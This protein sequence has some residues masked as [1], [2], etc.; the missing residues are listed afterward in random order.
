M[1]KYPIFPTGEL[2]LQALDDM[3]KRFGHTPNRASLLRTGGETNHYQYERRK[4]TIGF[5]NGTW[6]LIEDDPDPDFGEMRL[7]DGLWAATSDGVPDGMVEWK[8]G[9]DHP[10]GNGLEYG[11]DKS[12]GGN[13]PSFSDEWYKPDLKR[14][15]A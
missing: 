4:F 1:N 15:K 12:I 7:Y 2:L 13:P 11:G 3:E 10:S 8:K 6:F 5:D 9:D 14:V